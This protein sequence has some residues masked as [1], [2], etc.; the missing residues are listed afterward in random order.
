MPE[1]TKSFKQKRENAFWTEEI[2]NLGRRL[3]KQKEN[4]IQT[5]NLEHFLSRFTDY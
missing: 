3:H 2:T 4:F 1:K 5:G